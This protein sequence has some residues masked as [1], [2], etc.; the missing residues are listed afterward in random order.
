MDVQCKQY[1]HERQAVKMR[2][3]EFFTSDKNANFG[4][5]DFSYIRSKCLFC[6]YINIVPVIELY[7]LTISEEVQTYSFRCILAYL[8]L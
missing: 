6:L 4:V 5:E 1:D 2:H 7:A 8:V 3:V